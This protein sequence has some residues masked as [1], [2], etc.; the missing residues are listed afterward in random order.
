M[1]REKQLLCLKMLCEGNSI[2]AVER[3]AGVHRDTVMRLMVR[4]GEGC[5]ELLDEKVRDIDARH[6]EIDEQW[7]WVGKKQR[8]C[9]AV[10]KESG[11]VGDQ[12]LFLAFQQGA[13]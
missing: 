5:Q 8:H 10:E 6:L 4:F 1:S 7:T 13:G 2:R 12:Y 3:T 9:T 11:T